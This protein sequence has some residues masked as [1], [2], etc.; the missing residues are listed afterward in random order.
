MMKSAAKL[1]YVDIDYNEAL[2]KID[3]NVMSN[4]PK[5]NKEDRPYLGI[6]IE[7]NNTLY[8]IPL[9]SPDKEKFQKKCGKDM[10]K[11]PDAKRKN[12][13]GAPML[14]AVLNLNNM[15]P[16][17]KSVIAEVDLKIRPNDSKAE[18]KYKEL[19][20]NEQNWCRDNFEMICRKANKL[21]EQ[22]IQNPKKDINLTARCVDY[23]KLENVLSNWLKK[24]KATIKSPTAIQQQ[25]RKKFVS[26]DEQIAKAKAKAAAHNKAN[27]TT[28]PINANKK[29][30]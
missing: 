27:K 5:D 24:S 22:I 16:V 9:T 30:H 12:A 15:I 26:I 4:S 8:C 2:R 13:N 6:V 14:L 3:K 18:K 23:I 1:Y 20:Q 28:S 7:I 29:R 19:L 25:S 17:D 11:I 21:Y 10:V